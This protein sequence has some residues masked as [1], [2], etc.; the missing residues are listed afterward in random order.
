MDFE[1]PIYLLQLQGLLR[2]MATQAGTGGSPASE[3]YVTARKWWTKWWKMME[4]WYNDGTMVENYGSMMEKR[5]NKIEKWWN[6]AGK[7]WETWWKTWWKHGGKWYFNQET[8]GFG[9]YRWF[10]VDGWLR[11]ACNLHFM[12]LMGY[13]MGIFKQGLAENSRSWI[14]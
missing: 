2:E 11:K 1:Q 9:I 12:D 13:L 5:W 10:I 14:S 4:K 6:H 3:R 8:C 7:W